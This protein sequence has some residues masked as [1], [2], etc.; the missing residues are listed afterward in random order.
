VPP[1]F[2]KPIYTAEDGNNPSFDFKVNVFKEQNIRWILNVAQSMTE[3]NIPDRGFA[4]LFICISFFEM[5]G[6]YL[7]GFNEDGKSK[8][9][10]DIG[11]EFTFPKT[12]KELWDKLYKHVRCGF[13]HIGQPSENVLLYYRDEGSIGYHKDLNLI[14]F[15]SDI[16]VK[17]LKIKFNEYLDLICDEKNIEL[18]DNFNKRFDFDHKP[19]NKLREYSDD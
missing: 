8:E 16:L 11:L 9:H 5:M 19:V 10:F 3:H 7:K 6:K 1:E 14:A 4:Q 12:D 15:N 2:I 13:Y 17:D 18:R